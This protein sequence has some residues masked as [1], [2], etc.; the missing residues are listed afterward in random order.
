LLSDSLIDPRRLVGDLQLRREHA[1]LTKVRHWMW[2]LSQRRSKPSEILALD[3]NGS[4]TELLIGRAHDCDVL[5]DGSNVSR[6][7]ARLSFRDGRWILRDLAS[8]NGTVV[9]GTKVGRCE[10]RPGDE[11]VIGSHRLRVD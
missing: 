2:Q 8:T 1:P 9:N 6:L 5:L 4:T 3:W 7:H 10:L 11:L